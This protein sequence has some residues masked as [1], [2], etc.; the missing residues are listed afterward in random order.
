MKTPL[1]AVSASTL[2]APLVPPDVNVATFP[3]APVPLGYFL[4]HQLALEPAAEPFRVL[5]LLLAHSWRERPTTSL[6][7]DELRLAAMAGFGRNLP[8]W[9]EVRDAVMKDWILASDGRWYHPEF[10][11]WA[12]QAWESKRRTEDFSRLQSVRAKAGVNKRKAHQSMPE[13]DE[14]SNQQRKEDLLVSSETNRAGNDMDEIDGELDAQS[15]QDPVGFV[16]D[17]WR[18]KTDRPSE[19]LTSTRRRLIQAR[20][21]EGLTTTTLCQAIDGAFHDD[22]YQGRTPKQPAR[23]DTIDTIFKDQDRVM[24]L[25]NLSDATRIQRVKTSKKTD[26]LTTAERF[27]KVQGIDLSSAGAAVDINLDD[28]EGGL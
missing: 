14:V 19:E 4:L 27:A 2:Q 3:W 18:L 28:L 15:H 6:P 10:S 8:A 9:T 17:N 11:K 24:R 21:Q 22:F 25:A 5:V 26:A 7:N 1:V 12:M 20:L 16:F 13:Q 23:I